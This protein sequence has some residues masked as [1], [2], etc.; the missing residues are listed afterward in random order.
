MPRL[1]V[2]FVGWPIAAFVRVI[3]RWVGLLGTSATAPD[4]MSKTAGNPSSIERA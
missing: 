3:T 2:D 1:V 4:L